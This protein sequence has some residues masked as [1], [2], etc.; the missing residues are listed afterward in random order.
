MRCA[1]VLLQ[2]IAILYR[3]RPHARVTLAARNPAAPSSRRAPGPSL[4]A[5]PS[6][7]RCPPFSPPAPPSSLPIGRQARGPLIEPL[8]MGALGACASPGGMNVAFMVAADCG[9]EG[10]L[11]ACNSTIAAMIRRYL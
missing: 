6:R 8:A 1:A 4:R 3:P 5:R 7:Q 9:A 2:F 11:R 10:G